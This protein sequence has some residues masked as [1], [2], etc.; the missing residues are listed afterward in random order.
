VKQGSV[1]S[2]LLS[3]DGN[4]INTMNT[5]NP[6]NKPGFEDRSRVGGGY[7]GWRVTESN[8]QMTPNSLQPKPLIV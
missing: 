4:S 7:K 5:R 1:E 8:Q 3:A 6:I 2:C